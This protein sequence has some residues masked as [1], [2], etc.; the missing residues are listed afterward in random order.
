MKKVSITQS[1]YI[2]WK[3]YFDCINLVDDL[4]LYDEVQYT[5]RDWR[6]RNQIKTPEGL[7]WLSIPIQ[8]KGR[9]RQSIREARVSDPTWSARH[10]ETLRH[11]YARTPGFQRYGELFG[12]LYRDIASDSLSEINERFIRTVCEILGIR[13]RIHRASRFTLPRDRS[14]RLVSICEQLGATDYYTGPSAAAYLDESPF[15][16]AGIEVHYLDYTGYRFY[17]QHHGPFEHAVSILDLLFNV[18][19]D[20]PNYMKTFWPWQGREG[21]AREAR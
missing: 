11:A 17:P 8:V 18:G 6:N 14:R 19:P 9:Y 16:R 1:N 4:V 7:K 5:R 20:A 21:R 10:W 2:P 3:G 12:D 15:E 13:T